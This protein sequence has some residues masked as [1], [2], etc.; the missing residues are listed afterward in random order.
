MLEEHIIHIHIIANQR[1]QRS[2]KAHIKLL[3]QLR[4][5][6]PDKLYFKPEEIINKF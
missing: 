1:L 5:Q 6:I 3:I 4:K 2:T